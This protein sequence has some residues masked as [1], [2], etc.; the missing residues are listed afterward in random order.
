MKL[1]F[2]VCKEFFDLIY[3][4]V[5]SDI[6][7]NEIIKDEFHEE[8]D[9]EKGYQEVSPYIEDNEEEQEN[10]EYIQNEERENHQLIPDIQYNQEQEEDVEKNI[11][12]EEDD[13][14]CGYEL[15][16]QVISFINARIYKQL[17]DNKSE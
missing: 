12:Q 13:E 15:F 1:F 16:I 9:E 4:P 5:V 17:N 3:L 7:E 8:L 6:I 2:E 10:Y 11:E 14:F